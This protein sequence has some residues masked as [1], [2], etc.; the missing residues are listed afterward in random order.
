MSIHRGGNEKFTVSILES[1]TDWLSQTG[2]G[3]Y[4]ALLEDALDL[5]R[6][7]QRARCIMDGHVPC[8]GFQLIQACANRILAM[9]AARNDRTNLLEV[10]IA[11][12]RF[13]FS[14]SIFA[15][16]H[17]DFIDTA[18]TLKCMDGM[19]DDRSTG[20][21]GKQLVKTHAATVTGGDENSSKHSQKLKDQRSYNVGEGERNFLFNCCNF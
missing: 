1:V 16:D 20:D 2:S 3:V 7:D 11:N 15:R 10:F 18:G 19:R 14:M 12:N 9:F 21:R 4:A 5:F 13:D 8:T 6:G 17:S